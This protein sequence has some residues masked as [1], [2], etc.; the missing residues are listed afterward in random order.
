MTQAQYVEQLV[1]IDKNA[2]AAHVGVSPSTGS[3]ANRLSEL[4]VPG[5]LE[6]VSRTEVRAAA[7]LF[8]RGLR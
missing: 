5:L 1:T 7:T 8:P 3:W 6:D 4:R 2:L